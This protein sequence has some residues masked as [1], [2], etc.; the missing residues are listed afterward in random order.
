MG[1]GSGLVFPLHHSSIFTWPLHCRCWMVR[2]GLQLQL[3]LLELQGR[4]RRVWNGVF[5]IKSMQIS[6]K[7]CATAEKKTVVSISKNNNSNYFSSLLCLLL[8]DERGRLLL[9]CL[10]LRLFVSAPATHLNDTIF[11]K[12]YDSKRPKFFTNNWM[13]GYWI[14]AKYCIISLLLLKYYF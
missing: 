4:Q 12:S 2:Q 3:Q 5:M 6:S 11:P 1:R 14:N 13:N 9:R 10:R 8:P 7:K